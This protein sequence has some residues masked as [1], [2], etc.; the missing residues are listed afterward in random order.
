MTLPTNYRNAQQHIEN[1][2]KKLTDSVAKQLAFSVDFN[3][4]IREE[5]F[6]ELAVCFI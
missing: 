2:N 5:K 6:L 4:F 3:E 1:Y